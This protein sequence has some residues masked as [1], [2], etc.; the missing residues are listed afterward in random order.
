MEP[1]KPKFRFRLNL[2]DS[3]VLVLALAVGAFLVWSAI[4]PAAAPAEGAVSAAGTVQYTIRFQKMIQGVSERIKP[5]DQLV[6]TV[7]NYELGTVV[8]VETV[9]AQAL[10]QDHEDKAFV[11]AGI[12]GYED[13]LVTVEAPYTEGEDS[14]LLGGGFKL[15]VGVTAYV[16]GSGYMGSGP[17]FPLRGGSRDEKDHRPQ[18]AACSAS[19]ASSTCWSS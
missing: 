4:K 18:R 12:E 13:A 14:L 6:D 5:G 9:P 11:L 19:S 2:F 17:W 3:I 15:R 1:N 10:I 8:S 7:K 16:R